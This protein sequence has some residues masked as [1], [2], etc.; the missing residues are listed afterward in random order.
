M[1]AGSPVG[2]A[3]RPSAAAELALAER[4]GLKAYQEKIRPEQLAAI[5]AAAGT[6]IE[7]EVHWE[8]LASRGYGQRFLEP[9]W[10][11][12]IYFVPLTKALAEVGRDEIGREA[13][14]AKLQRIV[15][16]FDDATAPVSS[17]ENGLRFE[18]GTLV[19]NF[20]PGENASDIDWRVQAIVALLEKSL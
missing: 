18:A 12:D 11:T 3:V 15:V 6:P 5:Q 20:R 1:F 17:Y 7:V 4:R 9:D 2:L 14:K 8:K 19:I 16:T 10:F 13:I